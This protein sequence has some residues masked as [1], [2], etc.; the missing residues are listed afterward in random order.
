MISAVLLLVGT[1]TSGSRTSLLCALIGLGAI[2]HIAVSRSA[3]R[4]KLLIAVGVAGLVLAAAATRL[5]PSV[6]GPLRRVS[7]VLPGLSADNLRRAVVKLWEREGYGSAAMAMIA[8]E[9]LHGVGVG[10][11]HMLSSDYVFVLRHIRIPS[12]NA[13]NWFRHQFAELGALGSIGWIGWCVLM[14]AAILCRAQ[15]QRNTHDHAGR[16]IHAGRLWRRLAA[17]HP[18]SES[19]RRPHRLDIGLLAAP[20]RGRGQG[21]GRGAARSP[22]ARSDGGARSGS[23][24]RGD[25][26]LCRVEGITATVS[27]ETTRGSI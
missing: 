15:A 9:P 18:R 2:V 8:D 7:E 12:D 6:Q 19:L 20:A 21:P 5:A 23:R 22:K 17:R 11:F 16:E 4:R 10:T 14:A 13:Q 24:V 3:S 26:G 27:C 25:D 1:W